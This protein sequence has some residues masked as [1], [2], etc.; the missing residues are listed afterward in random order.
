MK[1][2]AKNAISHPVELKQ[3]LDVEIN[4]PGDKSISHRALILASQTIGTSK[5]S[6]L[7]ESEDVLNTLLAL[8]KLG[9]RIEKIGKTEEKESKLADATNASDATNATDSADSYNLTDSTDADCASYDYIVYG[10]GTGGLLEPS[11]MLDLGNSGTGVRL[12]MGLVAPYSFQTYFTGDASLQKRDMARIINPLQEMGA[13]F[14]YRNQ[15]LLPISVKGF[16]EMLPITYR[17]PIASAQVKSAILLAALNIAG[18][19]KIIEPE[20]SRNHTE[21]MLKY[22]DVDISITPITQPDNIPNRPDGEDCLGENM[23]AESEGDKGDEGGATNAGK[24][25]TIKGQPEIMAKDFTIPADPSSAAFF[26][27]YAL[28]TEKLSITMKNICLNPLRAGFFEAV[29]KMGANIE[30]LNRK[31]IMGENIA[32]V[33]AS[34]TEGLQAIELAA[35]FAPSMIDEYPILAILCARASGTSK[36]H[37]LKELTVKECNRLEVMQQGLEA[38]G[39]KCEV[40]ADYSLIIEGCA[41][42][43]PASKQ[44]TSQQSSSKQSSNQP[45]IPKIKTHLDH[46][47]AM[48]FLILGSISQQPI[49]IDDAGVINTSFPNFIELFTKAG[50]KVTTA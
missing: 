44:S 12:L 46:R 25:I 33:R 5:I 38:C 28:L 50:G 1:P 7:L 9:I 40:T 8:Q 17:L 20:P 48:S 6:N 34:F 21:N 14:T 2:I 22:L 4:I 13:E 16:S 10:N 31:N 43:K 37:G 45:A 47:I 27:A 41:S 30:F 11:D 32:D 42:K 29:K 49:Q 3:P 39:I 18:I 15:G 36:L 23:N 35:C 24:I 19:T 26:V